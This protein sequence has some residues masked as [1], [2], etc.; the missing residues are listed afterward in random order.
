MEERKDGKG[1]GREGHG[2]RRGWGLERDA[3]ESNITRLDL[4][5]HFTG[6]S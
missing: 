1:E 6:V 5:T 4:S 3:S 2:G